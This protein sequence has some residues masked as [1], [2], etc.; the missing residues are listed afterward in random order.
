MRCRSW[1]RR[2]HGPCRCS[3]FTSHGHQTQHE[4]LHRTR[5]QRRLQ[6]TW[7]DYAHPLR[8][9]NAR[10]RFG[11]SLWRSRR[12]A[13]LRSHVAGRDH[14]RRT[15]IM[16]VDATPTPGS[17]SSAPRSRPAAHRPSEPDGVRHQVDRCRRCCDPTCRLISQRRAGLRRRHHPDHRRRGVV[18][19]TDLHRDHRHLPQQGDHRPHHDEHVGGRPNHQPHQ[20]DRQEEAGP[21]G[22]VDRSMHRRSGTFGTG[23]GVRGLLHRRRLR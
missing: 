14:T 15:I 12:L 19:R 4:A 23:P 7:F 13:H 8:W 22:P 21:G 10:P 9:M 18:L 16:T 1:Q 17:R 3:R 6:H 2:N 20:P 11:L 5:D